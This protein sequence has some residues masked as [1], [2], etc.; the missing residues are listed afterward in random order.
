MRYN[1]DIARP[2]KLRIRKNAELFTV[3]EAF[4]G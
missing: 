4:A 3:G 1:L 2:E